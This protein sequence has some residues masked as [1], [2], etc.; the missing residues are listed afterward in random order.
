MSQRQGTRT[1]CLG[2]PGILVIRG[3]SL[4]VGPVPTTPTAVSLPQK[5]RWSID[6]VDREK[7]DS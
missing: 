4:C 6:R 2:I 5:T 7:S 1:S 3:W